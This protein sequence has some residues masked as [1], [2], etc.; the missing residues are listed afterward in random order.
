MQVNICLATCGGTRRHFE[1]AHFLPLK[2]FVNEICKAIIQTLKCRFIQLFWTSLLLVVRKHAV[3]KNLI[4]KMLQ[5]DVLS[6]PIVTNYFPLK[7][8]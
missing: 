6:L 1:K 5:Y 3:R 8:F 4:S 7:E 2:Q